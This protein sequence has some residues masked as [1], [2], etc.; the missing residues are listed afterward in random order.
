MSLRLAPTFAAALK[1]ARRG[2]VGMWLNTG[3]PVN[4]EIVAGAGF[5]WIL[6]DGEHSPL[7]LESIQVQLQILAAY[8]VTPMVRV[9]ENNATIIKQFLDLGAQNLLVPMV[10]TPEDAAAAVAA[11]RYPPQGVRGVG[12]ALSRG[13]RWNRV[14]NYVQ[15]ANEEFVSLTVQIESAQAVERAGEIAAVDGVDAL[16]IGPADLAA[17]MG[18]LGDAAHEDVETAVQRTIAA[19][20]AAGT[21]VGIN[22]FNQDAAHRYLEGGVDFALV[23]SDALLL[24]NTSA[25]IAST[26]IPTS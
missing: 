20:H 22:V 8:P 25:Q 5:D 10:N 4:A 17:T 21:P 12:A 19:A 13:G 16:F 24:A 1:D 15:R 2:L 9:P 3:S 6:I 18:H 23:A 14:E 7:G 11:V 26:F